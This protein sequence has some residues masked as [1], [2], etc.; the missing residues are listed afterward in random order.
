ME[1]LSGILNLKRLI[2]GRISIDKNQ[3]LVLITKDDGKLRRL[4]K[5]INLLNNFWIRIKYTF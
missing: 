2:I 1:C 5:I 4:T 3:T